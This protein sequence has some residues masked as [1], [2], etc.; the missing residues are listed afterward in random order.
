MA[1][2]NATN[3]TITD[4]TKELALAAVNQMITDLNVTKVNITPI[5]ARNMG[6]GW[7]AFLLWKDC[8]CTLIQV[9]GI[10]L[11]QVRFLDLPQTKQDRVY[12]R[13]YVD[14]SPLYWVSALSKVGKTIYL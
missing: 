11:D 2:Y 3:E 13:I 9:P 12:A 4:A 10:E 14:G 6:N 5:D 8:Y 1:K 7:F